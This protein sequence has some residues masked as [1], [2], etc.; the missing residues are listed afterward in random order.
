MK[1]DID[2]NHCVLDY[3]YRTTLLDAAIEQEDNE[4]LRLLIDFGADVNAVSES[5]NWPKPPLY[6]AI[7]KG[8][9]DII[10]IL[11]ERGVNYNW[12]DSDLIG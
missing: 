7:E 11:L 4:I 9:L 8:R 5:A 1:S 10:R 3:S 2:A 6:R 12:R